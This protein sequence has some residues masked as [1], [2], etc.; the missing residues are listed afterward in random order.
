M[1]GIFSLKI[2]SIVNIQVTA[3][4]LIFSWHSWCQET[5]FVPRSGTYAATPRWNFVCESYV[6]NDSIAIQIAKT[7]KGGILSI[8]AE[9]TNTSFAIAGNL[10][11]DLTDFG[12]I[13]CKDKSNRS[14]RENRIISYYYFTAAEM[15]RLQKTNI[16]A[17]RFCIRGKNS[18]FSSQT[19][20]FTASNK[21]KFFRTK[22]DNSELQYETARAVSQLLKK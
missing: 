4:L 15:S 19:G 3:F 18:G 2:L 8:E 16:A 14:V 1:I 6:M 21:R 9:T 5:M 13:I 20:Y 11:I 12:V 22:Y 7:E 10:Y 17:V